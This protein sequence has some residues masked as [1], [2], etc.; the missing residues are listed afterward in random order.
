MMSLYG[1]G[2]WVS[3]NCAIGTQYYDPWPKTRW[4]QSPMGQAYQTKDGK[5][6]QIFVN[7]YE[8]RWDAFCDAFELQDL[9]DDPRFNTRTAVNDPENCRMIVERCIASALRLTGD[10]LLSRLRAGNIPC[11]INGH[12]SDRY[13]QPEQVEHNLLNGYFTAHTYDGE[14]A[15][16]KTVFVSQFPL[17]FGSQGVTNDYACCHDIDEDREKIWK[18]FAVDL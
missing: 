5:F 11:C 14:T 10:E 8:K 18:E 1:V 7:E 2:G 16:G 4:T 3:Q 17:Y 12:F 6:V 9:H 15:S 13:T